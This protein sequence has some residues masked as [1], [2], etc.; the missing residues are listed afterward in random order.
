MVV[1]KAENL[2]TGPRTGRSRTV[3]APGASAGIQ[4]FAV[5]KVQLPASD[6]AL[7]SFQVC[8]A[9]N[10]SLALL[11]F[12]VVSNKGRGFNKI[13]DFVLPASCTVLAFCDNDRKLCVGFN[14]EFDLIDIAQATI[15]ELYVAETKQQYVGE[16]KLQPVAAIPLED[17]I[18]LCFN[19]A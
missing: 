15:T 18:L 14:I 4:V 16:I 11:S 5:S 2:T 19:R 6:A 12:G 9:M 7:P 1:N 13:K 8:V 10:R 3:C 17:D